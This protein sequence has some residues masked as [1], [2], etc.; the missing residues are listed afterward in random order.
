MRNPGTPIYHLATKLLRKLLPVLFAI[1]GYITA[2][3]QPAND[4]CTNAAEIVI[5]SSGFGMGKFTSSQ[6]DLTRS[7][8]QSGETF[9][10]S[11]YQRK[12]FIYGKEDLLI[13]N[14]KTDPEGYK[15][16]LGNRAKNQSRQEKEST[17]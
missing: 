14:P 15:K 17:I 11:N 7:T 4:N 3:A 6:S 10:P 9:A 16:A 2:I 5:S 13:P 12:G 1:T 8:L